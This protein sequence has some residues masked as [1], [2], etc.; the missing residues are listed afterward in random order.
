[1]FDVEEARRVLGQVAAAAP[2]AVSLDALAQLCEQPLGPELAVDALVALERHAAWL[3]SLMQPLLATVGDHA[4][5]EAGGPGMSTD[6]AL[7]AAHCEIAVALRLSEQRAGRDLWVA[8][9]LTGRLSMVA[10]ALAAG[11]ISYWHAFAIVESTSPLEDAHA[12]EIARRVLDRAGEQ[13]PA[14]LRRRLRRA[15]IAADPTLARKRADKA[16]ADRRLDW[17]SLGDG[18]AELRLIAPAAGIYSAYTAA[19]ELARRRGIGLTPGDCGWEPIDAR[20]SDALLDLINAAL[21][22]PGQDNPAAGSGPIDIPAAIWPR[23]TVHITLDLPTALGLADNPADLAGYGP[24][25]AHLARALAADGNWHRLIYEPLTGA[26][27]DQGHTSYK[28]SAALTRFI[29]NRDKTCCFPGCSRPAIRC[30]LDHTIP[31]DP[32]Q[33]GGGRTDRINLGDMCRHHH[34]VK[35]RAGWKA[36]RDRDTATITWTSPTGHDYHVPVHDHRPEPAPVDL[37]PD[38]EPDADDGVVDS[39]ARHAHQKWL[40]TISDERWAAHAYLPDDAPPAA[41]AAYAPDDLP[42]DDVPLA[43]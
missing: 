18:M 4:Q 25:P 17:W 34:R 10:D 42:A 16:H 2:D 9:E 39:Y 11:T 20:R 21:P 32:T 43:A 15:V 40:D 37:P 3:A 30:D 38:Q 13:T 29:H 23:T 19:D 31:Y 22:R 28:P 6:Q 26:L 41:Y 12:V 24:L 35:H 36:R 33:P 27:L 8:R 14:Q 5:A 7:R 1:M